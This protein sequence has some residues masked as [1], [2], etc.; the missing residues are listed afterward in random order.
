MIVA[1]IVT[2]IFAVPLLIAAYTDFWSMKIPNKVSLA[3]AAGFVIALPMTW[4]GLP[5]LAEHLSVGLVFFAAGFAMFALGWLGGGDAKLMAAISL[6]FGWGDVMPFVLYTTLFGAALGI[7]MML[8]DTL[9]PVRVRTSELGMRMFQGGKDMPYGL[10]LAAGA[11]FVWPTSSLF[12][13]LV[14]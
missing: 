13:A 14:G 7:F 10:A 11:L 2:L 1:F 4:Q 5:A 3:M 9:L 12:V 8:S 6:W